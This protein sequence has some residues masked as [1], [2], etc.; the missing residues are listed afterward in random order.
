MIDNSYSFIAARRRLFEYINADIFFFLM[1]GIT[2]DG[3]SP[4]PPWRNHRCAI[5][6]SS[7]QT[8]VFLAASSK[9]GR[10]NF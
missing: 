3:R 8:E 1:P 10:N 9:I 2:A 6:V 7:T 4:I 5:D